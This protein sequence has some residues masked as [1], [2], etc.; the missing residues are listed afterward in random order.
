MKLSWIHRT[1]RTKRVSRQDAMA[2]IVVMAL[3]SI[4]LIFLAGNIRTLY[5]LGRE[6]KLIEQHQTRRLKAAGPGTNALAI[7]NPAGGQPAHE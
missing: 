3:I 4:L 7:T 5:S 2:T 1:R 6:L